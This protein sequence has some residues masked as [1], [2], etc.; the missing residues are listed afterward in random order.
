MPPAIR[1]RLIRLFVWPTWFVMLFGG[2][3][4]TPTGRGLVDHNFPFWRWTPA[5]LKLSIS[6]SIQFNSKSYRWIRRGSFAGTYPFIWWSLSFLCVWSLFRDLKWKLSIKLYDYQSKKPPVFQFHHFDF[7]FGVFPIYF[8]SVQTCH[9]PYIYLN[10]K[11]N[12]Y[13]NT[14]V[15]YYKNKF[16]VGKAIT[17]IKTCNRTI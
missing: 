9:I 15:I 17:E 8:H 10:N 1:Y 2:I 7:R 14:K 3:T 4:I 16:D 6:I 11:T 12:K 13:I 5:S